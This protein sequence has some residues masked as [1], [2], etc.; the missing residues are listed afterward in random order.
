[1]LSAVILQDIFVV[2][3]PL[4]GSPNELKLIQYVSQHNKHYSPMIF[5][6]TFSIAVVT[7][8]QTVDSLCMIWSRYGTGHGI[9][10]GTTLECAWKNSGKP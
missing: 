7:Q 5:N 8:N 1:M 2:G 9:I 4:K 3:R 6:N 10:D